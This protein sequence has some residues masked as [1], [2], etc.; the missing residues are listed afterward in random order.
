MKV[1]E[2]IK[3][4]R[5]RIDEE[6]GNLSDMAEVIDEKDDSYMDNIIKAKINDALHWIAVTA[7]SSAALADSKK[8]GTSSATLQVQDYDTQKS[9]GVVTMDANTEVINISRI[10]GKGWFKAVT[11]I[12]DTQDEAVMMFDETAFGTIDRPQAAIMRE[13]PLKILLQPKPTEAVISYVGVP[14]NV[15]ASDSTDV[16]IPDRLKNA[17]IYYLAFL[18]LSAYDDTKATQMYTI[19]LQQLGVSQTSKQ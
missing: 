11:P 9:I 13:N 8:I 1:S 10:R 15:S 6:S 4:V 14:K 5:W 7:S 16:A 3:E 12:E 18:L 2:I 17:F 19:A